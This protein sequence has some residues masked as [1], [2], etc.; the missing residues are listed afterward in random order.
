MS[1]IES[2]YQLYLEYPKVRK[3]TRSDV[4]GAI[5]FA[6]KGP[7]FDGNQFAKTALD[8][9]AAAVVVDNL[10][11]LSEGDDRVIYVSDVQTTL[12]QLASYHRNKFQGKVI[13]I[14]GSNGKTTT[15]ELLSNVLKR[16]YRV[17]STPGN[18]NNHIGIPLMLLGTSANVDFA[19]VEMGASAVGEIQSYCKIVRP[20]YGIITNIGQAHLEGFG[21][22]EGVVRGKGELYDYLANND[23]H[24]FLCSDEEYLYEMAVERGVKNK[25]IYF[26]SDIPRIIENEF[27]GQLLQEHP[28][29]LCEIQDQSGDVHLLSSNLNGKYNYRN[30]LAAL[31]VGTFFNVPYPE[32]VRAI[33]LYNPNNNRSQV[34]ELDDVEYVL[35]A[36]NANPTSMKLSLEAFSASRSKAKVLVIGDMLELGKYSQRAHQE[37][38]DSIKNL[39]KISAVFLVGKCFKETHTPEG[40][41]K[42]NTVGDLKKVWNP[43]DFAGKSVFLKGSRSLELERLIDQ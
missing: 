30:I 35:D 34:F 39:K 27:C 9:G 20:E 5:Y 33:Q 23:G 36:Y 2:L 25:T 40:Y 6:L 1:S 15:K 7:R 37:I 13:A 31:S 24:A 11:N 22:I 38:V 43:K 14:T 21:G 10:A 42:F 19:V 16:R 3:D 26:D 12:Q 18:Y 17:S 29:I 8:Q 41:F 28:N 4:E 32:M